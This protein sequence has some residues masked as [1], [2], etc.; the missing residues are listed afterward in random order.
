MPTAAKVRFRLDE[1]QR[2]AVASLDDRIS[3]AEREADTEA[4]EARY[5]A[6]LLEWRSRQEK[7]FSDLFRQ[8]DTIDDLSLAA[9]RVDPMPEFSRA[10]RSRARRRVDD[11]RAL[12]S[13]IAARAASLVPDEDGAVS[14][15]KTQ[16]A[17][18][19][20]L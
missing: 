20:G 17:D 10:D 11:L 12:R 16:L 1:L 4:S 3:E 9:F 18:I 19:F 13:Q 5:R 2:Q 7:R 6:D 14:L 8:L 15:T